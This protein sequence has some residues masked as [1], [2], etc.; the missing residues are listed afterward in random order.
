MGWPIPGGRPVS[1]LFG[2]GLL[3]YLW[4][5]SSLFSFPLFA[6]ASW[7]VN[8]DE[9]ISSLCSLIL[10]EGGFTPSQR[11]YLSRAT[12][13]MRKSY[14]VLS[15]LVRWEELVM[16]LVCVSPGSMRRRKR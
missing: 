5:G 6:R 1:K 4:V 9:R 11:Y 12:A 15:G 2:T 16:I 3:I 7:E 13:D 10:E 8:S 14:D